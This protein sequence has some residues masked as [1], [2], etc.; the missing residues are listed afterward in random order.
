MKMSRLLGLTGCLVLAV[1]GVR[2]EEGYTAAVHVSTLLKTTKDSAGQTLHYPTET[3]AEITGVLVELPVGQKTGWHVHPNPCVAY[4]L[5]GEVTV[6]V[7]N[8]TK[9]MLQAGEAF[10]EVVGLRHCGY[11]TGTVPT[12]ILLFALGTEGAP[13]SKSTAAPAQ[14]GPWAPPGNWSEAGEKPRDR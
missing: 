3:A 5:E 7:E 6:E 1:A 14:K 10:T 11:N 9:R 12:K 13:I 4:I 2:A 8:G